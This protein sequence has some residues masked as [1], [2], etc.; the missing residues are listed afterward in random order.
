MPHSLPILPRTPAG[1]LR[2]STVLW[3][4]PDQQ[5]LDGLAVDKGITLPN[6]LFD[7]N[8]SQHG[9]RTRIQGDTAS[10]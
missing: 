8:V 3:N 7:L 9:R 5:L 10:I 6:G 4:R 2:T 1:A